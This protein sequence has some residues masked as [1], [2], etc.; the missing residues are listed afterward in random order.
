MS[1]TN[2]A[3]KT[4]QFDE[5]K[6]AKIANDLFVSS[7]VDSYNTKAAAAKLPPITTEAELKAALDIAAQCA[8]YQQKQAAE[9]SNPLVKAATLITTAKQAS[10]TAVHPQLK[11]D[12]AAALKS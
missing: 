9:R 10:V 5:A 12:L 8:D 4:P 7:F 6:M 11:K 1:D 3:Q 2:T